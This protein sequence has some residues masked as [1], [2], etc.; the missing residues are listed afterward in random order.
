MTRHCHH[1]GREWTFDRPPGRN[2]TCDQCRADLRV[3]LNCRHYDPKVA[4]QCR[5]T[6][7]EPVADKDRANYCEWFDFAR[8]AYTPSGG[9]DRAADARANL[10]RLLGD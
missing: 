2:D 1:C 8:R 9:R 10:K 6:R 4:Q 3:C 7:A 5:E